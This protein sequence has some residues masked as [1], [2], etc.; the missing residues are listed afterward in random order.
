[1]AEFTGDKTHDP[2]PRRRQQA[3]D[4]GRVAQS[5]DLG[6]AVLLLG[7]L[8]VLLLAGGAL[9]EF[10]ADF[11]RDSLSGGAW[12]SW[13]HTNDADHRLVAN[14]LG[15]L[16]PAL[17]R[18]L[19]PVLGGAALLA[20]AGSFV[21]TGFL[22]RARRIAPDL[23]RVNPLAGLRRVFSGASALRL[24]LG[25]VKVG[26]VATVAFADLWSRREELA[27]LAALDIPDLA[28]RASDVCLAT[29][30]KI[31]GV[32]LALSAVDYFYQRWTLER[33]LKMTPQEIREEMRELHGDPRI[34]ARRRSMVRQ[35]AGRPP[36]TAG[37]AQTVR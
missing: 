32:L 8:A 16:A 17:A 21:Q 30:L 28:A 35:S 4:A 1:M 10:L 14:Q 25:V 34:A 20:I 5:Q 37:G 19:L 18:R 12:K 36:G 9:V 26:V 27:A 22:V 7:S 6:S 15:A 2:T 11:L 33:E 3:R 23:S 24:A 31:G 13:I 29:C